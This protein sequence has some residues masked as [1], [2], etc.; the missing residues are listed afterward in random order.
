MCADLSLAN[1]QWAEAEDYL[2][3][4]LKTWNSLEEINLDDFEPE[5][6]ELNCL[7]GEMYWQTGRWK[8]ALSSLKLAISFSVRYRAHAECA[9]T[10]AKAKALLAE[11]ETK[12]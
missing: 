2:L 8:L 10:A 4:A 1:E 11:I 6:A 12:L 5:M 7:F 9:E 3:T